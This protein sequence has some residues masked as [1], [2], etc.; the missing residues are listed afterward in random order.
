MLLSESAI[1]SSI[2]ANPIS[3]CDIICMV[4]RL[5]RLGAWTS[6]SGRRMAQRITI[7]DRV[8]LQVD[9]RR[10]RLRGEL[11]PTTHAGTHRQICPSR[12]QPT[13][14]QPLTLAEASVSR[15]GPVPGRQ[16]ALRGHL[17]DHRTRSAAPARACSLLTSRNAQG[18]GRAPGRRLPLPISAPRAAHWTSGGT[19]RA[20]RSSSPR[21]SR[22]AMPSPHLRRGRRSAVRVAIRRG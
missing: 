22:C 14:D 9:P 7:C 6:R 15:I 18:E 19:S 2:S 17:G 4:P 5:D 10:R 12:T 21:P 1:F 11:T 13:A 8:F 3:A 16:H 20:S